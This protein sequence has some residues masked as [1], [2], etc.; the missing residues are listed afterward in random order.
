MKTATI[1]FAGIM[2]A[3]HSFAAGNGPLSDEHV[4]LKYGRYTTAAEARQKLDIANNDVTGQ[5]CCRHMAPAAPSA[6]PD[7]EARFRMKLGRNTQAFEA[8]ESAAAAQA[9]AHVAHCAALAKCPLKKEAVA[10]EP[11]LSA[12]EARARKSFHST[13]AAETRKE[14]A[15]ASTHS[16]CQEECCKQGQ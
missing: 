13:A 2:I 9:T 16:P 10:A 4:Q 15:F 11:N 5:S 1:L 3:S 12:K 14:V 7:T 6:S 8:R